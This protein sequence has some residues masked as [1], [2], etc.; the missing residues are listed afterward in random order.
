M[1][2][3]KY[4]CVFDKTIE[5]SVKTE[6]KL[7]P[8]SLIEFCKICDRGQPHVKARPTVMLQ[9]VHLTLEIMQWYEYVKSRGYSRDIEKFV[10]ECV[11]GFFKDKGVALA[12]IIKDKQEKSE[13]D[14]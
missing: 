11:A 9:S 4:Y 12:M 13:S 6:Y 14:R 1:E 2:D 3:K 10:N 5:C 7:K 8:E